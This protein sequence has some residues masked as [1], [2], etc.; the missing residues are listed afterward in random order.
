MTRIKDALDAVAAAI[1]AQKEYLTNLDAK[2]GDGDHGLNMARGFRAAQEAVEDMEDTTRPGPVL[3]TIGKALIQNVGGAA[4]PLYGTGFVK[5]GEACDDDTKMN[6]ASMEKLLRIAI[7]AIQA[8]GRADKGDKTML[9]VLI[10]IHECFLP[11]NTAE[12]T[13][14]EVLQEASKAAG[15][16]VNF[17]KTIAARKGRASLVGERSI[18][19]EDPGAVSS[20]IM[21]RALYQFLKR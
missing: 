15:D 3:Q 18:G 4:G 21:Y 11:D 5:A 7:E 6:V 12:K 20:M 8:R 2:T 9:D 10:P 1:I 13:L 17:T 14:F 16:G 19:I